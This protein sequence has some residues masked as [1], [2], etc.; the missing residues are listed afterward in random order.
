MADFELRHLRTM[1]A[2]AEEGTITGAAARLRITQPALS[3]T[4]RQ[5][6]QR[7][8]TS[9]IDRSTRHLELTPAGRTLARRRTPL[10]RNSA[11]PERPL[12]QPRQVGRLGLGFH[13]VWRRSSKR[14]ADVA[15]LVLG[16]A[17]AGWHGHDRDLHDL[18]TGGVRPSSSV[19]R[20]T[21]IQRA[22]APQRT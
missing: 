19:L 18:R 16:L 10:F 4:L 21:S 17:L 20:S 22:P 12:D 2:I 6:E 14:V 11:S 8:G 1:A 3:R 5:L 13:H 7:V 9:L 15:V